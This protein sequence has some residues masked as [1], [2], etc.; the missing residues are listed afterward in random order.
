MQVTIILIK[1]LIGVRKISRTHQVGV[2]VQL[3]IPIFTAF[4]EILIT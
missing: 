2:H 3:E 1:M 4:V